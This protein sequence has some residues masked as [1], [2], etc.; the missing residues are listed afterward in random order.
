MFAVCF[1]NS[2]GVCFTPSFDN[3]DVIIYF[4]FQL[5][6][7]QSCLINNKFSLAFKIARKSGTIN[8]RNRYLSVRHLLPNATSNNGYSD[9]FVHLSLEQREEKRRLEL[10]NAFLSLE[11]SRQ[12]QYFGSKKAAV[13][14]L[15]VNFP[16]K[17]NIKSQ[18]SKQFATGHRV[19][20]LV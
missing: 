20:R 9:K 12:I 4:W 11:N 18:L 7:P 10:Y 19:K 14:E 3:N 17:P 1:L 16:I 5:V 15:L 13:P 8:F 2:Y 6:F